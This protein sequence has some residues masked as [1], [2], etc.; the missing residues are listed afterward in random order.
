MDGWPSGDREVDAGQRDDRMDDEP[1]DYGDHVVSEWFGGCVH[2]VDIEN[3]TCFERG[4]LCELS[5]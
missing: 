2:V 4:K 1:G 3:F 5:G